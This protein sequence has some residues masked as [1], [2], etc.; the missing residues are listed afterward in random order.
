MSKKRTLLIE[1]W[2]LLPHSYSVVNFYQCRELLK[3]GDIELFHRELPYYR[4]RWE[5]VAGIFDAG[6]E[7]AFVA[8]PALPEGVIPDAVLRLGFPYNVDPSP[9]RRVF[10][11]GTAESYCVTP[12]YFSN[13]KGIGETLAEDPKLQIITPSYWSRGGFIYLG[14]PASRVHV[15]PHGVDPDLFVPISKEERERY[16]EMSDFTG[17]VFLN[18]G[19]MT[20]N[21]GIGMILKA[22]AVVAQK[23]PEIKLAFK[24]LDALYTSRECLEECRRVLTQAETERLSTRVLY[25]G[26]TLNAVEMAR[27]YKLADA[28]VSPYEAEGFNLPVLEAIAAGIPAICTAGGSTDDFARPPFGLRIVSR[29]EDGFL[30]EARARRLSVSLDSLIHHMRSVI[31]N[32]RIGEQAQATGP[33]FVR[34]HFTWKHAVDRLLNLM[35]PDAES[36]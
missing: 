15:V 20:G 30:E 12:I 27:L 7:A 18:V 1:S 29:V 21:K 6:E 9:A 4:A 22:A 23:H 3:R 11:F 32:P 35:F 13:G 19:A 5:P 16:R 17:F 26:A 2:R 8:I 25:L 24:G 28:Y 34:E 33:A 36:L 14:A 10:V 31:E